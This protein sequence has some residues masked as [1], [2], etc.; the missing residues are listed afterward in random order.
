MAILAGS[1]VLGHPCWVIHAGSS[2]LGFL[3]WAVHAGHVYWLSLLSCPCWAVHAKLSMSGC[4]YQG[5]LGRL[6][7]L[8]H[9]YSPPMH[10]CPR[11]V[12]HEEQSIWAVTVRPSILSSPYW[13]IHSGCLNWASYASIQVHWAE[14]RLSHYGTWQSLYNSL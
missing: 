6:S 13:P 9:H 2:M 5:V 3:Y 4:P 1:S 8:A 11:C 12:V 7:M 10:S 14:T